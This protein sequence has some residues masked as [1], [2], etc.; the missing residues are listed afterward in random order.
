MH[1]FLQGF[2]LGYAAE[3]SEFGGQTAGTQPQFSS[4]S[5]TVV[6]H[7]MDFEVYAQSEKA[8]GILCVCVC[9]C[10]FVRVI[11]SLD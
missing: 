8:R 2:P 10:L 5:V 7:N 4:R 1:R 11:R 3:R 9:A 6:S